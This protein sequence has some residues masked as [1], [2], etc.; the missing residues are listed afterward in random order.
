MDLKTVIANNRQAV[1]DLLTTVGAVTSS[2]WSRPIA[3]GKWSPGQVTEHV[4]VTYEV[5]RTILHGDSSGLTV[6]R[7]VRPLIR[8]LFL[9][10][11]LKKGRFGRPAK[12]PKP[13]EPA[14]SPALPEIVTARLQAAAAALEE[15]IERV[16]GSGQATLDHPFFGKIPLADYL[17][18]QAI[19]TRHHHAQLA[20]VNDRE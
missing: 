1:T 3:P 8:V 10:S 15:D 17:Q 12:T 18:F 2:E 5:G 9:N 11:V 7:V 20:R 13:F 19:H 14:A 4:A 6:P 16:A